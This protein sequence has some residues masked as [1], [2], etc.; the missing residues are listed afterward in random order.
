MELFDPARKLITSEQL[1]AFV[2]ERANYPDRMDYLRY[3]GFERGAAHSAKND[4]HVRAKYLRRARHCA[5]GS[6][7]KEAGLATYSHDLREMLNDYV[8]VNGR[9]Y[10]NEAIIDEAAEI[11]FLA[12]QNTYD[13]L[14][15]ADKLLL[16]YNLNG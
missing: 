13:K 10:Y 14:S 4:F 9:I 12:Y 7:T 15:D 2:N 16:T 8:K 3:G 6:N 5:I 1:V 11:L